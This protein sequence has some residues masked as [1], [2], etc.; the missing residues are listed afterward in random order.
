[1]VEHNVLSGPSTEQGPKDPFELILEQIEAC[2][3]AIW[4]YIMKLQE[5]KRL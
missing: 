4:D 1:M 3:A 2:T 5:I